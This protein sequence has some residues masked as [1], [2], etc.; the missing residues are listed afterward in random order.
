MH[1]CLLNLV[2]NSIKATDRGGRVAI[3][4]HQNSAETLT[5]TVS[6]TGKGMSRETVSS[7]MTMSAPRN[8]DY[9]TEAEGAG[10]GLPITKSLVEVMGGRLEIDSWVGEGTEVRLIVPIA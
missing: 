2:S 10:L 3:R 6:D 8:Q 5:F 9:V 4:A 1:Q 7:L